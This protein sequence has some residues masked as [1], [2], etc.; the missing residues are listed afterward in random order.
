MWEIILTV[1]LYKL[2]SSP[3][4]DEFG[5]LVIS[6]IATAFADER[7]NLLKVLFA[8]IKIYISLNFFCKYEKA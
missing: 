6:M 2:S 4:D 5:Y 8:V 3:P 1:S 7:T